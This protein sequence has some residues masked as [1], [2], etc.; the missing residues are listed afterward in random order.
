MDADAPRGL[1]R[2]LDKLNNPR[3]LDDNHCYRL[4]NLLAILVVLCGAE[5]WADVAHFGQY[6]LSWLKT[7]LDLEHGMVF[8]QTFGQVFALLAP[9]QLER[10]FLLLNPIP[11]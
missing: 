1:L 5:R 10:W 2:Y 8:D 6:K 7:F 4:S 11:R 3:R 9:D